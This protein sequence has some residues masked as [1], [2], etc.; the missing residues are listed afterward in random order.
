VNDGERSDRD[1][2]R[3]IMVTGASSGIGRATAARLADA[4]HVV[5]GAA[6]GATALD[7]LAAEHPRVRPLVLDVTDRASIDDARQQIGTWTA[8]HG[9]DVVVNVAGTLVLGPVEAVPE[10]LM[11]A[12]FEVNVFG[13]LAVTRAFLPPMRER[14]AGRI[15]NVS[16][17]MGRFALPGSGLYSASKFAMEAYSDALRI[18]L[19]PF[20]VRV[21]LVEPGVIDTPLYEVAASSLPDY[22]EALEPYRAS[23]TA[24]FGFP[25][26]LL[27]GAASVDSIAA[28]LAKAALERKP[29]ARYRPGLRNRMN[30]RLLTTLRTR[31]TDRIKSRIAGMVTDWS[32]HRAPFPRAKSLV[33]GDAGREPSWC[34]KGPPPTQRTPIDSFTALEEKDG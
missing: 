19:A 2:P 1:A 6:R 12:Q 16:S 24:G 17:I 11:R 28:T 15:V 34:E 10:E 32:L 25:E 20:G 8:G 31:S 18:E 5:F 26:R 13:S 4:G 29:R 14:G 33:R 23:W 30:T 21:V 22:D 3:F 27:K 7:A 9:L